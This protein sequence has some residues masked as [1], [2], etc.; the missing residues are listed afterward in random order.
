M[1]GDFKSIGRDGPAGFVVFLVALPLC[2]GIS[3]ASNTPLASGVITGAIA[4]IVVSWLSGS[5]L[6]V[7]GPAAGLT[8]TIVSA[9][10]LLGTYEAVLVSIVLAGLFQLISGFLR[11]GNLASYFPNSVI[12]GML[13]GIGVLIILKQI[14]HAVGWDAD[15]AGDESFFQTFDSENS[16]SEILRSLERFDLGSV[17]IAVASLV[18]LLFWGT[19]FVKN[20]RY[21]A[22]I[23]AQLIAI[24]AGWWMNFCLKIGMPQIA[25]M[26]GSPHLVNIPKGGI[27]SFFSQLPH[28]NWL[29]L[30]NFSTWKIAAGIALIA[31]IETLLS[32]EA[33]DKLD[34]EKRVSDTNR[35]LKAQGVGNILCGLFGG[36]PMTSVIVRSSANVYAGGRTRL[37]AFIHGVLLLSAVLIVPNLLNA[38]PLATLAVVLI[39][40]GYKLINWGVIKSVLDEGFEQAL[41]FFVT[42]LAIIFTDLLVGVGVGLVVGLLIVVR[43][44][45]HS[46]IT[47]GSDGN[48][49]LIRFAKDV[50]F[51]HKAELKKILAEIPDGSNL[52]IDGLGAHYIDHDVL[53]AVRDFQEGSPLRNI[54]VSLKNMSSKRLSVRG[55]RNG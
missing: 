42:G 54:A 15:F 55:V 5:Q 10:A 22:K 4:G 49:I 46:A 20:N 23:P 16:F 53:E 40:V 47:Q 48:D 6:S 13:A 32:I 30:E 51:A 35:E 11:A 2:L 7:S 8:V 41:P 29:V 26:P 34:P 24:A 9:I 18:A 25:L 45:H 3:L 50:S 39:L 36:L 37:S 21:L 33:S 27:F 14:P 19:A 31:S 17:V 38:I 52:I 12:K 1:S 44:N 28:P 43:M